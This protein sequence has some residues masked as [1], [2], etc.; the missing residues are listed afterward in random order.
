MPTLSESNHIYY[1]MKTTVIF[2]DF[3]WLYIKIDTI[4]LKLYED[5]FMAVL[6]FDY[7]DFHCFW[8]FYQMTGSVTQR[9]IWVAAL[10]DIH[11]RIKDHKKS[12]IFMTR[13]L[14]LDSQRVNV[15]WKNSTPWIL[16][17]KGH[18]APLY[19]CFL[20]G[21]DLQWMLNAALMHLGLLHLKY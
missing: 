10:L 4:G 8:K 14:A 5:I 2:I 7:Q 13:Y 19:T 15:D 6:P 11:L 21:Q 3:E 20:L 17:H 9:S 1:V 18:Y 16:P 12:Q